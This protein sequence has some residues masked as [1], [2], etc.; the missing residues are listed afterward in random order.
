MGAGDDDL[1]VVDNRLAVFGLEG[2]LIADASIMPIIPRANTNLA[3]MMVG[4]RG[5]AMAAAAC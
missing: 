3:S 4:W 2:L 1:A 5:A